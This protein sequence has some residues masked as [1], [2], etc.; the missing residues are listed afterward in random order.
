MA[1]A[2]IDSLKLEISSGSDSAR[3]GLD[4]LSKSLKKLQSVTSKGLGLTA[5]VNE[6]KAADA[7]IKSSSLDGLTKAV[8]T[9]TKLGGVKISSSI[10]NQLTAISASLQSANF[11]GGVEKVRSLVTA[12]EPLGQLGQSNLS[13]YATALK[14]L[15]DTFAE[16][17]KIDMSAFTAKIQELATALKP[18]GDE[19]Q[20]V[21]NGFSA[22]PAKIQ[23]L[24]ANTN[25]LSNAN[26][27][28][29]TSYINL[30]AKI[31]M[32]WAAVKG[33]GRT[34]GKWIT[35]SS[36]Y[37]ET[38]NL[39]TVSM[40]QFAEEAYNYA[41][42]VGNAMGIDPADW[43]ESQGIFMTLTKGFGVVGERA[44]VMSQQ[45]TQLGYDLSSFFNISVEDAMTKLQSG[46]S[47]E[48]EPLR[49]LGYDL[50][51]AKL[52]ATA[53]SLG[54][55]KVVSSM[56]QAEKAEL[57]YYAIMTQVTDA[58]GDMARTLNAPANQ[59]RILN[60]QVTQLGRALGNFFI[61][62]L[63]NTLPYIIATVKVLREVL[64]VF[65]DLLGIELAEVDFGK[66]SITSATDDIVSNLEDGQ[67][68]AK[69]LKSYML[70][71]DELNVL[72]V[73]D[74][75]DGLGELLGTGFEFELP[76]YDFTD[77][78]VA[79]QVDDIVKKMK[80]WLGVAETIESKMGLLSTNFG[81]IAVAVGIVAIGLAAWKIYKLVKDTEKLKLAFKGISVF[82]K[83]IGIA[84][85]SMAAIAGAGWLINNTE[86]TMTKIGAVISAGTLAVGA[87][88]AFTGINLPLGLGLMAVGAV[89]MG[90]AIAMNTNALS[91]E[92]KGVIAFI[93]SFV[94]V[95]LLGVGAIL[96]FTGVNI[97]LGIALMAGGA[98]TMGSAVLPNWN[99]LS[100]N[101]KNAI[102][103]ITA[104]LGAGM[105]AFGAVF[106]FSG[107]NIPLGIGLM[108]AGAVSLGTAIALNW[109]SVVGAMRGTTGKIV[110]IVGA[111]LLALGA[112]LAFTGAALPLGI[113]LMAVGALSLGSAIALNWDSVV[114]AM[115]GTLGAIMAIV[116]GAL[117]VLG[118][119]LLFTGVG[120]P[121]GLG[122]ILGGAA[123]LGTAVAFNWDS[124]VDCIKGVWKKITNFWNTYIAPVFTLGF[125]ADIGSN[126][127]EG[128]V[129]GWNNMWT[130]IGEW[131]DGFIDGILDILG[132]H[133]PSTVF[134]EI[135]VFLI[136]GLL[137]GLKSIFGTVLTW[138]NDKLI[139]PIV[140]AFSGIWTK[141]KNGAKSAW[142]GIKNVF[143][144]VATFFKNVFTN[145]WEGV[146]KV[147]S[148]GGKIFDG[149]KDGI[150]TAFKVVVNGIIKGINKV[151][152]L[153]FKGLNGIL[154]TIHGLSIAGVE[155]FK[156]LTW[157]A[158]VPQ[159]PLL[160]QG[161]FPEL[162][163]MFIARESGAEL[164]GNIGGRT[165]VMNNDQ[166]VE[167]VS[168]GVYQAV[169]AALGSNTDEGGDTNIVITLDGEKIYENQQK[170]ARRRGYNLGMGAFSFG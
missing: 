13:S 39:F 1:E 33:V 163:Q 147:F 161:G 78:I 15:P 64:D 51:Q 167:S 76:T 26:N 10:G 41:Q 36:D 71:F 55:D 148:V 49:R 118:L 104:I 140:D 92:V 106:A 6:L 123:S 114:N 90:S 65:M 129:N 72:N 53:L 124:I 125:W 127:V 88:L 34:I 82:F 99:E 9:L 81:N 96:A 157:R 46:I 158:P 86:D 75:S 162:G 95:A 112:V 11:E 131:W 25:N 45:L 48:L 109:D 101:V 132:I 150:V 156:W 105:L 40:G 170:V 128:L 35:L 61:P 42:T 38:M 113:G 142:E 166:I 108:V 111:S 119:I 63:N 103:L 57:R 139:S 155:P 143:G 28:A 37:T 4:A 32:A 23:K 145:A 60:A 58:H 47:G 160:A 74:G 100:D 62:L 137:N 102:S 138:F 73:D 8:D 68:E 89:S 85:V 91:D 168:A 7:S 27:K 43:M 77:G 107:A 130:A 115:R 50:S 116:G 87:V 169:L 17:S 146:K 67:K 159:I 80:E 20:K 16:L 94:S 136:K 144:S 44:D 110:A 164:V 151:V 69:K 12:L 52:E 14:K 5:V 122:L 66:G 29:S 22:F 97:P 121:L 3:K 59:M 30:Y 134:A 54:I 31:R 79:T 84:A 165:A 24:I 70:G 117:L 56:T 135:G 19:M 154:D 153:P 141:M 83:A 133:S 152:S 120:I 21:A 126:I 149:I 2:T 98:L 18:L 93:T